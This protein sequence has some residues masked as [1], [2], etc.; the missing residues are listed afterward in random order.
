[1][2]RKRL[3]A[4]RR[5][6]SSNAAW[7]PDSVGH[8]LDVFVAVASVQFVFDAVVREVNRFIEVRQP[9]PQFRGGPDPVVRR[10]QIGRGSA[11]AATPDPGA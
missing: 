8:D 2:C 9:I 11:P 7:A 1:M 5:L 4:S 10:R 3:R 6:S